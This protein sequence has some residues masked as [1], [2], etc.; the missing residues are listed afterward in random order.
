MEATK[1]VLTVIESARRLG[2]SGQHLRNLVRKGALKRVPRRGRDKR[3]RFALDALEALPHTWSGKHKSKP[4]LATN[5]GALAHRPRRT[6]AYGSDWPSGSLISLDE[7]TLRMLEGL[8]NRLQALPG[9]V[10]AARVTR[11]GF[12]IEVASRAA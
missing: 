12:S 10:Q 3:M 2:C 9:A 8:R 5:G 11:D 1:E 7:D 4:A 6:R